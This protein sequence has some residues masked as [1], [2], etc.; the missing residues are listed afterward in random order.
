MQEPG[1]SCQLAPIL[2]SIKPPL[3]LSEATK[4]KT[5]KSISTSLNLRKRRRSS[6]G[7]D[8]ASH[9]LRAQNDSRRPATQLQ[10]RDNHVAYLADYRVTPRA[11]DR[12]FAQPA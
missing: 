5:R 6:N 3:L 10:T 8:S 2:R 9:P 12:L 1:G 7:M 4:I 11:M